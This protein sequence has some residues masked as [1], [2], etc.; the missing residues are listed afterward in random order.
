MTVFIIYKGV[1]ASPKKTMRDLAAINKTETIPRPM[2]QLGLN[3][4]P[5]ILRL[6][7]T[8]SYQ[9]INARYSP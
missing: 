8:R 6:K 2:Y 3:T 4:N 1:L 9:V 7:T 5:T